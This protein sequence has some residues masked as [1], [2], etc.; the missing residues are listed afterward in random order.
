MNSAQAAR[1]ADPSPAVR[2]WSEILRLPKHQLA[3]PEVSGCVGGREARDIGLSVHAVNS[4]A[5]SPSFLCPSVILQ[6]V[7]ISS[8][9]FRRVR[10]N[11][12]ALLCGGWENDFDIVERASFL[13]ASGFSS[14]NVLRFTIDCESI[15][16]RHI[17][18][19]YLPSA[20][21]DPQ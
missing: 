7:P 14:G 13:D 20:S 12:F 2:L 17:R 18:N 19:S 16:V 3:G 11:G 21:G 6:I 4:T 10:W 15:L 1:I 5:R 8:L 9:C